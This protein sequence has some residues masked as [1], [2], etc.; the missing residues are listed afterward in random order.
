MKH[1][2][3][4]LLYVAVQQSALNCKKI[5]NA[6]AARI[7]QGIRWNIQEGPTEENIVCQKKL[8]SPAWLRLSNQSWSISH[9]VQTSSRDR[10]VQMIKINITI[11]WNMFSMSYF[12]SLKVGLLAASHCQHSRIRLHKDWG[13]DDQNQDE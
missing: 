13:Q 5:R 4:P 7:D 6:V 3:Y 8:H 12:I 11:T 10:I 9:N 2:F 1:I